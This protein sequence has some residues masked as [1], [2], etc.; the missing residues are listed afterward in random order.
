[1]IYV[2]IATAIISGVIGVIAL[3]PDIPPAPQELVAYTDIFAGI[4]K[5][6]SGVYRYFMSPSIAYV[7]LF[8]ILTML[9]FDPLYKLTL[10]VLRKLPIGVK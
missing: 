8:I 1:M 3:L 9:A 5:Q 2:I 4:L 10:W 7:T 6:I